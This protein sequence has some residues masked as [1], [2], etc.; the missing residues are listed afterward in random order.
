MKSKIV[1]FLIVTAIWGTNISC[2]DKF[3]KNLLDKHIIPDVPVY[4]RIDLAIGGESN[5]W[6][7]QPKY[8]SV[9][10]IGKSLGYQ[11]HGIIIFTSSNT[12][13]KCYDA[14]C[15]NCSDLSS[16]F[17]QQ[18]LNGSIAKCPVCG[19][20]FLLDYG[21][22]DGNNNKIYPLKEYPIVKSGNSLT[23]SYK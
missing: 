14:T 3:G 4:T 6:I 8:F 16:Y 9:S 2:G 13:Y 22:P 10:S 1:F 12:D 23:V 18:D 7:G 20:E 15:T 19:T 11:G 21:T 5:N 17:Q